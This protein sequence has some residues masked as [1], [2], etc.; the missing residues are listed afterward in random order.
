MI[1]SAIERAPQIPRN[2]ALRRVNREKKTK[3]PLFAHTHVSKLPPRHWRTMVHK[4]SYLSE[5]FTRPPLTS[6]RRQ[7]N[8]RNYLIR[9]KLPEN[10][11]KSGGLKGMNKC[12]KW[13]PACPY[14]KEGKSVK[15]KNKE[16]KIFKPYDCNSYNVVHAVTCKKE[17]CKKAKLGETKRM[18]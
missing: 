14:I 7:P 15:I 6:Y 5:V 16:W 3:G 18:L 4:N 12:C 17:K 10:E 9:A 8:I 11:K 1:Y 2:V 13:C